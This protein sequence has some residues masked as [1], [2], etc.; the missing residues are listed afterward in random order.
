M[1]SHSA[2]SIKSKLIA[3]CGMNC[4][5]CYGYVR[6]RNP[7]PGCFEL[8]TNKPKTRFSCKIRTCEKLKAGNYKY[9]FKCEDFP[10]ARLKQLDKRYRT[11][12]GMS[13]IN[14]LEQIRDSGIRLFI[15][16]EKKKWRCKKCSKVIC[17]HKTHC[18]YC[19]RSRDM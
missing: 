7:C 4:A 6:E 14:N 8:D 5:L 9:C 16:A 13:M 3:P 18:I 10:C 11:K 19:G 12:Y 15:R 17:V 2:N 1:K